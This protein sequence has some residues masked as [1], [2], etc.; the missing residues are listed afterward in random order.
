M[1]HLSPEDATLYEVVTD[2][3]GKRWLRLREA[4][5]RGS[6]ARIYL[7]ANSRGEVQVEKEYELSVDSRVDLRETVRHCAAEWGDFPPQATPPPSNV[8]WTGS[9]RTW[10]PSAAKSPSPS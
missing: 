8:R 7:V 6:D 2:S 10:S 5:S 1:S 4:F 9:W 3:E